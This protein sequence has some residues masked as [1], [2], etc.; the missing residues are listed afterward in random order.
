MS[1]LPDRLTPV[2]NKL[3]KVLENDRIELLQIK[4]S[5]AMSALLIAACPRSPC[6]NDKV[7]QRLA[8]LVHT[9][10]IHRFIDLS[11]RCVFGPRL[12]SVHNGRREHADTGHHDVRAN[13]QS[14][15]RVEKQ[16]QSKGSSND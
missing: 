8:K 3:L 16:G 13:G 7:I 14:G 4:A 2:L 12:H 6:P 1:Q 15:G 11:Q 10:S 5:R 9:C